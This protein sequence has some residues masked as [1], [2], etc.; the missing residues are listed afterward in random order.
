MK[1]ISVLFVLIS[2]ITLLLVASESVNNPGYAADF[3][4]ALIVSKKSRKNI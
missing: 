4:V 1:T 3:K 2:S